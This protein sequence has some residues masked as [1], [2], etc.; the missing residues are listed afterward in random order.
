MNKYLLLLIFVFPSFT[1][2]AAKQKKFSELDDIQKSI[3]FDLYGRATTLPEERNHFALAFR[4]IFKDSSE[5]CVFFPNGRNPFFS[6]GLDCKQPLI[7]ECH[8]CLCTTPIPSNPADH[9]LSDSEFA[10][11]SY[12]CNFNFGES[13]IFEPIRKKIKE[14]S[15]V[16]K[17]EIHGFSTRDM[18]TNCCAHLEKLI[19]TREFIF[20]VGMCTMPEVKS[21]PQIEFYVSSL[22]PFEHEYK[23]S[24]TGLYYVFL[25]KE[26]DEPVSKEEFTH[27]EFWEIKKLTISIKYLEDEI[28]RLDRLIEQASDLLK[29]PI[30]ENKESISARKSILI[31]E[32]RNLLMELT[33]I[34]SMIQ[35]IFGAKNKRESD[36][37]FLKLTHPNLDPAF[38]KFLEGPKS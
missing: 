10:F 8:S 14:G 24:D 33:K 17:I 20:Y 13:D 34:R 6:S 35:Y 2:S 19:Q 38:K 30:I 12:A 5:E 21:L 4:F 9:G 1:L 15:V 25:H 18:C 3:H 32:K 7:E 28:E 36:K 37:F 11:I 27:D 31:K 22:V 29:Q 16:K 26:D 23:D